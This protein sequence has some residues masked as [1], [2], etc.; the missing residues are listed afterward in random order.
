MVGRS[1]NVRPVPLNR[2]VAEIR[3]RGRRGKPPHIGD[4]RRPPA[5]FRGRRGLLETRRHRARRL[6]PVDHTL[7]QDRS[8]RYA[9]GTGACAAVND[10]MRPRSHKANGSPG[11][12]RAPPV[13]DYPTSGS[14][15]PMDLRG[16]FRRRSPVRAWPGAEPAFGPLGRYCRQRHSGRRFG[17]WRDGGVRWGQRCATRRHW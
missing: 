13:S 4:A 8:E 1:R 16:T 6:R 10:T 9:A 5:P 2:G 15:M 12:V 14:L 7:V 17:D 11:S 3:R